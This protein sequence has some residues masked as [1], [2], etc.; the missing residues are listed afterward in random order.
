MFGV[1]GG[2]A[3]VDKNREDV[4]GKSLTF[5]DAFGG[6]LGCSQCVSSSA[7]D[8]PEA[9]FIRHINLDRRR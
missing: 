3:D 4:V 8:L 7:D 9:C 6:P 1:D 5:L 2:S